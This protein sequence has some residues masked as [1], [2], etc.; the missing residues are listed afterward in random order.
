MFHIRH[1][2]SILPYS[3]KM[4]S[5]TLMILVSV[6]TMAV[7]SGE[8]LA[9]SPGISCNPGFLD[10]LPPRFR[11]ICMAFARIWDV[12][13]MNDFIDDKGNRLSKS[14]IHLWGIICVFLS[15][16]NYMQN[17]KVLGSLYPIANQQA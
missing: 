15:Y 16:D 7:L 6:T 10:E 5:S 1:F 8:A 17:R 2:Y 9:G 13:D 11:K 4:M 14:G 3:P 12:R